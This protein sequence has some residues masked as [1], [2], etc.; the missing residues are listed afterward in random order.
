MDVKIFDVEH[1]ACSLVTTDTGAHLLIDC[2]YNA[3]TSW[4]PSMYLPSNNIFVVDRL[5]ITNYDEDHVADLPDLERNV[6]IRILHRNRSV[7]PQALTAMKSKDGIG[8]GIRHLVD[9]AGRYGYPVVEEPDLGALH[10]SC[11]GISIPATVPMR[12]T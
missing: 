12:I 1:G 4:R 8:S 5:F 6:S 7:S 11:F 3:T 9:M 10:F 2:G